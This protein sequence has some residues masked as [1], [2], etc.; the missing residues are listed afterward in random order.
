MTLSE[1]KN[2]FNQNLIDK[3]RARATI[4][5]YTKDI[6]QLIDYL[7]KKQIKNVEDVSTED[8]S[9]FMKSL[10]NE[11]YTP[12]SISRKTNS[13]KTF[14]KYLYEDAGAIK[15]NPADLV[16]HPKLDPKAPRILSKIEYK[17]LRDVVKEDI[18]TAAIVEI[19]LQA[20]L[21]ISELSNIKLE[22]VHLSKDADKEQGMLFVPGTGNTPDREIPL[23]SS[24]Q[25]AI[26]NYLEVR[27]H[28]TKDF[29]FVTKTGNQLLVRNIRATLNKYFKEIDLNDVKVNDLRHTFIAHHLQN[30]ASL[31]IVSKV[32][33]HKRISTTE[34]YLEYIKVT[35]KSSN[36]KLE[37]L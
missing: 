22:D 3:G 12:K 13:T 16:N 25:K 20:G 4:I 36:F 5:A 15:S 18:R 35:Q 2:S 1:S 27:P 33:G 31:F 23:N 28:S 29:L 24:V 30:G 11:G 19:L 21:R 8:L 9:D 34:K 10:A 6:D 37:E 7:A 17:A 14:F 32:A 26:S